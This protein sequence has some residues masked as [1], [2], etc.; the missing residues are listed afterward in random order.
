[1]NIPRSIPCLVLAAMLAACTSSHPSL[2]VSKDAAPDLAAPPP[3]AAADPVAYPDHQVFTEL[4]PDLAT[5][6]GGDTMAAQPD[7]PLE[8]EVGSVEAG[9][10]EAGGIDSASADKAQTCYWQTQG[11]RYGLKHFTF[12]LITPDGQAQ[13]PP[14]GYP[15]VDA[16]KWPINDFEGLMVSNS[17][18]QFA[19]DSCIPP[20]ACA[21]SVYRFTLCDSSSCAAAGS[22]APIE[23]P[24]PIGR[25]V[26]VVWHMDNYTSFCPGLYWLAVYDAEAGDS[27]GHLLFL[28]SGGQEPPTANS[29]SGYFNDL[30]FSVGVRPLSCGDVKRDAGGLVGDDYAFVFTDKSGAWATVEL[31]TG[32]SGSFTFTAQ[33]GGPQRLQIHCLDAVQPGATDDYW[34]WDFWA[35]GEILTTPPALD[36]ASPLDAGGG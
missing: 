18:N 6:L 33:A 21:S 28:G 24:I 1:M 16:G 22:P 12:G 26:R 20:A 13:T 17:G 36:A 3:D 8:V 29:P 35:T 27:Q 5:E 19:V 34:N 15:T 2:P 10:V 32:E 23:L 11:G 31:A 9:G 14:P 4:G 25:H 7:L 30:P